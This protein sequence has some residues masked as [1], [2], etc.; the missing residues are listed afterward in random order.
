M[1]IIVIFIIVVV[2][3]YIKRRK[4]GSIGN[5]IN[6]AADKSAIKSALRREEQEIRNIKARQA[7]GV[8]D[9]I[10]GRLDNFE[11]QRHKENIRRLKLELRK[12]K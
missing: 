6:Y 7:F 8:G 5:A 1:Y 12:L 4:H 10:N 2:I 3:I 11:I 9:H